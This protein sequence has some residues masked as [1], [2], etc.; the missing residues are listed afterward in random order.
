MNTTETALDAFIQDHVA[1]VSE[2]YKQGALAYFTATMSGK[3]TDYQEATATQI[4]LEKVYANPADFAKV[5][6]FMESKSVS[7]PLLARQLEMLFL[8]YQGKQVEEQKL[9][10]A[11]KIQTQIEEK[12]STFRVEIEGKQLS[13]N[14]IKAILNTSSR[15]EEVQSTWLASKAI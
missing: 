12:F 8:A 2:L 1:H 15:S 9:E 7:D 5:V 6:S 13:D 11:V 4:A 3:D 10:D 14:E